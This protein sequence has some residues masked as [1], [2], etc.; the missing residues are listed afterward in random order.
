M[1]KC[2]LIAMLV[3][4]GCAGNPS[5]EAALLLVDQIDTYETAIKKK[6]DAEQI[7]YQDIRTALNKA[8]GRQAWAE[9]RI[10]T[11]NRIIK[12]TDQAIVQDKGLQ[13]SV[14]QQFLR[15]ENARARVRKVN[16][17]NRKAELEASYK[18]SFNSLS[19]RQQQLSITRTKLL[20][21]TQDQS[22]KD[23]LIKRIREAARLAKTLEEE[24]E[25]N[26]Q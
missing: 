1:R 3:M 10:E 9:Q 12:L 7:F 5:K 21:L 19:F 23:Q 25:A 11:H 8:A 15:D 20:A 18:V 24:A 4:T 16:E 17:D 14:L 22:A 2:L 26:S 13:V 6:I